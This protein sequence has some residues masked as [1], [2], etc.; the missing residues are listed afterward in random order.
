M[1]PV[2]DYII[3]SSTVMLALLFCYWIFWKFYFLRDPSR[4]I[5]HGNNLIAPADGVIIS[6]KAYNFSEKKAKV[7]VDK[8]IGKIMTL[9]SDI[10]KE[11]TVVSIFMS[12]FDVHVN[13]APCDGTVISTKHTKGKFYN[14]RNL[15]KSLYNE[16]NEILMKTD[17]GK[18]K[19]IQIAGFLARRI[20]SYVRDTQKVIK[21][22]RIGLINLGSQVTMILP[23]D[24]IE[25]N[26]RVGRK[27]K[28]GVTIIAG[29]KK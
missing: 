14:A 16:K 9:A 6:V 25:L 17:F 7:K 23:T 26:A 28:A 18:I 20:E 12:P 2:F 22:Q 4:K 15:E 24:K 10:G 1:V 21:G 5:P 13:R 27:V 29:V 3:V 11:V 19:V 8:G